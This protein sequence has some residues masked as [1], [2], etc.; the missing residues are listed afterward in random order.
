MSRHAVRRILTIYFAVG[1]LYGAFR[2]LATPGSSDWDWQA[3]FRAA[4]GWALGPLV[5]GGFV[6][7]LLWGINNF[8]P[9]RARLP[10]LWS[11]AFAV[12]LAITS[13]VQGFY[14]GSLSLQTLPD[15]VFG[16]FSNEHDKFVR[17]VRNTCNE[18]LQKHPAPGITSQQSDAFCSCYANALAEGLTAHELAIALTSQNAMSPEL[19]HRVLAAAPN[20]RKQAFGAN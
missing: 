1:A 5:L 8:R 20:C 12:L 17:V 4:L 6:P 3:I 10:L 13:A 19:R 2:L 18:N 16:L 9:E 14:E 15:N 11:G 7:I